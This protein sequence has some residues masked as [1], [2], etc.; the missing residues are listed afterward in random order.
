V[1]CA[2]CD[3]PSVTAAGD[4]EIPAGGFSVIR[5]VALAPGTDAVTVTI[6]V[7]VIA[8]GAVYSPVPEITPVAGEIDHVTGPLELLTC[9]LNCA[10]CDGPS[11]TAEGK[12]EIPAGR[13]SVIRA[14]ALAP[15]I[16]A[17]TVMVWD[18][19]IEAGAV[20][21][22]APE[23]VPMGG[24]SDHVT[25][26]LEL[27]TWA[28]NCAVCEVESATS[29]GVTEIPA[30]AFSV[31]RAVPL[32]PG[33]EAVTVTTW[34]AVMAAGAVYSPL[35]EIVPRAGLIDHVA[36]PEGLL[37]CATNCAVCE[38]PSVTSPGVTV[39]VEGC[40]ASAAL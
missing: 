40:A 32:A 10:V 5:A 3:G 19:V 31:I 1:N 6:W 26:L 36:V 2:V 20:Y 29:P 37:T 34:L 8:A 23:I 7:A 30:G 24:Y 39:T 14:E 33:T 16:D 27:V 25:G 22:P 21:S 35:A 12:T 4:T 17:V 38:G 13:F 15:G 11:V 9:T 18:A 28:V